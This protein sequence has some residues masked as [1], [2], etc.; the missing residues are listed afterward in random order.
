MT[1][2]SFEGWA[3][4]ELMGHRVRIGLVQEAEMFGV[5]M[6][7]IDIPAG[8]GTVTEFYQPQVI[9]ALRPVAEEIARAEAARY[10][11]P[12]PVQPVEYRQLPSLGNGRHADTGDGALSEALDGDNDGMPF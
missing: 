9:Y 4:L 1:E 11:D 8:D 5:K 2:P 6:L 3:I 12:R 10:G 7:R